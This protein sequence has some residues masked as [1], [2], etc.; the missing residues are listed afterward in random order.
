MEFLV[1]NLSLLLFPIGTYGRKLLDTSNTSDKLS[2]LQEAARDTHYFIHNNCT[3]PLQATMDKAWLTILPINIPEQESLKLWAQ[4]AVCFN[5]GV[6]YGFF[7]QL[8]LM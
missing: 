4:T 8:T 5:V 1:L 3:G 7:F 6:I 2:Y